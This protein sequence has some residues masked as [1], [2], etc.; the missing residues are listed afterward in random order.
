MKISSKRAEYAALTGLVLSLVFFL[1]TLLL[2]NWC[3]SFAVSAISWQILGG[4]II[5]LVLTIQFHQRSP[6]G[7]GKT[8]YG[9]ACK[10]GHDDDFSGHRRNSQI[11]S[12]WHR[13]GWHFL[14]NGFC[15]FSPGLSEFIKSDRRLY[16]QSYVPEADI[17]IN[18]PLINAGFMAAI[19]L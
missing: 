11:F 14:K 4:A 15:R 2:G 18:Q 6:G 17:L 16:F 12:R 7:A 5:W 10:G 3:G 19:A 13:G 1:I 9:P 8:R